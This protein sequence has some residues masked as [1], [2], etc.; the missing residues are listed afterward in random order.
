VLALK[1]VNVRKHPNIIGLHDFWDDGDNI[2]IVM[3]LCAG[4]LR[5]LLQDHDRPMHVSLLWD[6]VHQVVL[7]LQHLH[8]LNI[9]HRDL[10][11]ENGINGPHLKD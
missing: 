11:P 1:A 7:G 6:M 8:D 5:F 9:C 3:E 2:L 4:D 10:K